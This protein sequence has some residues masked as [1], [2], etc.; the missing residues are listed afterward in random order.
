M[1]IFPQNNAKTFLNYE[2]N[3]LLIFNL[4]LEY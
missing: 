4:M 1:V 3:E 2:K